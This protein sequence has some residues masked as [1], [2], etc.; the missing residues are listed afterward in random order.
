[1]ESRFQNSYRSP[2]CRCACTRPLLT[3]CQHGWDER[4]DDEVA[5][6]VEKAAK[7]G[8]R[9]S[10]AGQCAVDAIEETIEQ[11]EEEGPMASGGAGERRGKQGKEAREEGG[12]G[13]VVRDDG[14]WDESTERLSEGVFEM[15]EIVVVHGR[16]VTRA[17]LVLETSISTSRSVII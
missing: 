7:S 3:V 12:E 6:E 13:D 10:H 1:M 11:P 4:V 9:G 5:E 17:L 15:A 16:I 14:G 2:I 8:S